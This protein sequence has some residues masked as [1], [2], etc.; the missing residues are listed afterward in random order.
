MN[1]STDVIIVG[2]GFAGLTAAKALLQAGKTVRVLEARSRVGGRVH[3]EHFE[4]FYLDMGG[5]W[6]GLRRIEFMPC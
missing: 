3:T 1:N 4:G 2:A 6:V 5:T